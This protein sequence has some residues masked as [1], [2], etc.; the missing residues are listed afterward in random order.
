[1][2]KSSVSNRWIREQIIKA[3]FTKN[4]PRTNNLKP[5]NT[6]EFTKLYH[7]D[8]TCGKKDVQKRKNIDNTLKEI[9]K[10]TYENMQKKQHTYS[11]VPFSFNFSYIL[12]LWIC[13]CPPKLIIIHPKSFILSDCQKWLPQKYANV[14]K[15]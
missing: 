6:L 4:L 11:I 8:L 14:Q 3:S 9:S 5:L 1:M 10:W 2:K 12:N 7:G 15:K 13:L